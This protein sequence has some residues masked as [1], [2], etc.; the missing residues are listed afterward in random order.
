MKDQKR[1]MNYYWQQPLLQIKVQQKYVEYG[2]V[3]G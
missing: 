2:I 1:E 3:E